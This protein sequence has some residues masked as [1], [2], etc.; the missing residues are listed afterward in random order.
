MEL[1]CHRK[2]GGN[3]SLEVA[4]LN[5]PQATTFEKE[6]R[7][8]GGNTV[9]LGRGL[10]LSRAAVVAVAP[11]T[12]P[13]HAAA[14]LNPQAARNPAVLPGPGQGRQPQQT[15]VELLCVISAH[16]STSGAL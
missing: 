8:G 3:F 14:A 13:P 2:K 6:L 7:E 16:G 1:F 4:E 11:A 12:T 9:I 10:G 15:A 5:W